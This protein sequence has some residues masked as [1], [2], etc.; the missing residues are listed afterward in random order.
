MMSPDDDA[1][2]CAPSTLAEEA[3]IIASA[4]GSGRIPWLAVFE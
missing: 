4:L 2:C 1:F 3:N